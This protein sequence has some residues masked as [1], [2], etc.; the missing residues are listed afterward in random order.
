MTKRGPI[1]RLE[2]GDFWYANPIYFQASEEGVL[3][4]RETSGEAEQIGLTHP[5]A[6]HLRD[7]LCE[8]YGVP[9]WDTPS[10]IGLTPDHAGRLVALLNYDTERN[11]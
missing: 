11:E 3:V 2:R 6:R 8:Q 10:E 1:R 9:M 5:E 7:L 4:R